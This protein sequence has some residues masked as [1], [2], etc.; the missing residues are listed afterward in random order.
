[1]ILCCGLGHVCRSHPH[2]AQEAVPSRCSC[3]PQ[4][5]A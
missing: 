1:V 3:N 4:S 2:V 5:T